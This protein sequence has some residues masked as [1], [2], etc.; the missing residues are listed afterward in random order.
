MA[1][2]KAVHTYIETLSHE[3][4][5]DSMEE[6]QSELSSLFDDMAPEDFMSVEKVHCATDIIQLADSMGNVREAK[7]AVGRLN[8]FLLALGLAE[9]DLKA[10][11]VNDMVQLRTR[12]GAFLFELADIVFLVNAGNVDDFWQLVYELSP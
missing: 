1:K 5:A 4:E 8:E 7:L 12:G 9:S 3:L 2:F 11:A 10:V 6:A